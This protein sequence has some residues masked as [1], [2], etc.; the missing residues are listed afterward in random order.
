MQKPVMSDDVEQRIENYLQQYNRR[1]QWVAWGLDKL[2]AQGGAL[3]LH[4]PPGTGK[5]SI[6]RYCAEKIKKGMKQLDVAMLPSDGG[7]GQ[8]EKAIDV[9]FDDATKRNNMLIFMDECDSLMISRDQIGEAGKTW[10]LGGTE[11]L[12]MRMNTYKGPIICATNHITLM[13]AALDDRFLDII[14]IDEPDMEMRDRLWRQKIPA[15]FPI[16]LTN[17][18]FRILSRIK[19][20]GRRIE[21]AIIN[22]ALNAMRM[23]GRPTFLMLQRFA[24][25]GVSRTIPKTDKAE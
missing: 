15:A 23:H 14:L 1:Q 19:L 20:N 24:E 11:K 17:E 22:A 5:T 12:M 4:G 18:Q 10:Q 16:Q 21:I 9:F 13:D 7:P 2:R 25:K 3:L 6:A 8:F